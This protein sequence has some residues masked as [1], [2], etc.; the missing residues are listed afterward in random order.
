ML[1]VWKIILQALGTE[2]RAVR[3]IRGASGFPHA[4][5]AAGVDERRRRVIL[6]SPEGDPRVAAMV[7]ADIQAA[8]RSIQILTARAIVHDVTAFGRI[9]AGFAGKT[10]VSREEMWEAIYAQG[11]EVVRRS[12]LLREFTGDEPDHIP[13]EGMLQQLLQQ[14]MLGGPP[15]QSPFLAERTQNPTIPELANSKIDVS[16]MD[17]IDIL[18]GDREAGICPLPFVQMSDSSLELLIRGTAVDA[19]ADLLEAEGI[20]QYFFP[21]P[22][23]VALGL[24]ERE[25]VSR[26]TIHDQLLEVPA[27]GHPYSLPEVLPEG[28]PLTHVIDVLKEKKLV[29]EGEISLE[30]TPEGQSVRSTV[31]FKPRE[32]LFSKL[33]NRFTINFDL[34]DLFRP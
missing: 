34:K 33:I 5:L 13:I 29:V 2:P 31:R 6:I 30:V 4:V 1:T 7:Q 26:Q 15:E 19:V 17:N 9:I 20:A 11:S 28:T 3:Q 8:D 32:S 22:D 18:A 25:P 27:L 24:I 23:H 14:M 12:E 16:V 10:E 21:T